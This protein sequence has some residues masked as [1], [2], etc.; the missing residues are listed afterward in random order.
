MLRQRDYGLREDDPFVHEVVYAELHISDVGRRI[1]SLGT[2]KREA[3]AVTRGLDLSSKPILRG[4]DVSNFSAGPD[5]YEMRTIAGHGQDRVAHKG[6]R[7]APRLGNIYGR[8][9]GS[10]KYP[11]RFGRCGIVGP[12]N[13]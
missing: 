2:S 8:A 4:V 7:F 5:E 6:S 12:V 9:A 13:E 11:G 1:F 3:L 10:F